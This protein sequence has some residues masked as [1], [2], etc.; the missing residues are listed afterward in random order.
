MS[1]KSKDK[2]WGEAIA[3]ICRKQFTKHEKIY[4]RALIEK[5]V[6]HFNLE[7]EASK[8]LAQELHKCVSQKPETPSKGKWNALTLWRHEIGNTLANAASDA[9]DS[10]GDVANKARALW[11]DLSPNEKTLWQRRAKEKNAQEAAALAEPNPVVV[12]EEIRRLVTKALMGDVS[13]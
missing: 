5:I 11:K 3:D 12:D 2:T 9:N 1:K 13:H 6:N 7:Q 4:E 10:M 8:K